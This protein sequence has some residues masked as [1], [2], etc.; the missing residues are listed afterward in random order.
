[1]LMTQVSSSVSFSGPESMIE[2]LTLFTC[3]HRMIPDSSLAKEGRHG[4]KQKKTRLTY[5]FTVN[6]DGNERL[7]PLVMGHFKQPRCFDKRTTQNM[8]SIIT[9]TRKLG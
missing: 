4:I 3:Y 7:P 9:S 1:M 2:L 5:L 6:A 8:A